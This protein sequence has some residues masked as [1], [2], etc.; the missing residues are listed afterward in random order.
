MKL[1]LQRKVNARTIYRIRE[2]MIFREKLHI[3]DRISYEEFKILYQRYADGMNEKDFARYFFDVDYIEYYNCQAGKTKQM[4]IL[5]R[6]LVLVQEILA[7]KNK[8]IEH[9][10]LKKNDELSYE[11][12]IEIYTQWGN[13]LSLYRFAD[14]VLNVTQKSIQTARMYYNKEEKKDYRMRVLK[15]EN[16]NRH[17]LR[18]IQEKVAKESGK[19]IKDHITLEEFKEL[20]EKFGEGIEEKLFATR[21]LQ[22]DEDRIFRFLKGKVKKVTI[23]NQYALDYEEILA[24]RERVIL[25]EKLHIGDSISKE[26]FER[27]YQKYGGVLSEE[28][29]AE[30]VLDVTAV[31][32]TNMKKGSNS[33]ILTNIE[34]P[35]DYI[36]EVRQ[37]I[38]DENNFEQKQLQ[39]RDKIDSLYEQYGYVLSRK[40]FVEL[41]LDT[42]DNG[43]KRI[44]I[45][46]NQ[47][48]TDFKELRKRVIQEN[49]LHYGDKMRY[50]VFQKLHKKYA[51]NVMEYVFAEKVFD[52]SHACYDKMKAGGSTHILLEEKLPSDAEL[53]QVKETVIR[54]NR[55]HRKDW[56]N[57]QKF[58]EY[59]LK[60]GGILPEDMFAERILDIGINGLKKIRP[61]KDKNNE[62]SEDEEE[63]Q[64]L[65]RTQMEQE[66]IEKLKKKII[67][68]NI[69]Y[70]EKEVSLNDFEEMYRQDEHILSRAE[71]A[72]GVLE[73]GRSSFFRL[74]KGSKVKAFPERKKRSAC[75]SEQEIKLLQE[76]LIQDLS[77]EEI[78]SQMF[79]SLSF[80]EQ[81]REQILNAKKLLLEKKGEKREKEQ[82][83]LSKQQKRQ[84][85]LRQ[86]QRHKE[87]KKIARNVLA[88]F[89]YNEENVSKMKE[90]LDSCKILFETGKLKKEELD[91]LGRCIEFAQAGMEYIEFFLKVCVNFQ[92]YQKA[93][94]FLGENIHNEE[95]KEKEKE[96]LR[97]LRANI[98]HAMK[99]ERAIVMICDQGVRDITYIAQKTGLSRAEIINLKSFEAAPKKVGQFK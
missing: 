81:N 96:K 24:L 57:Y 18:K 25:E 19:H 63:T 90:Y 82:E 69:L 3:G 68:E 31:G 67:N 92:E 29:F 84:A 16:F 38:I 62:K 97:Q 40:Q 72:K 65:L 50:L 2:Q 48:T 30:E 8:V 59:Y 56:I 61:K 76:Y 45:L 78:A 34:I 13:K 93:Y 27:L 60:Y 77:D 32:V 49:A 37:K 36:K 41:I 11:K 4:R 94:V 17:Q 55:L 9:Y 23:L 7:I 33:V 80:L 46:R 71:F 85:V 15:D 91:F 35:E 98:E 44:S 95:V 53:K 99:K 75:F 1:S 83:G 58:R 88:D 86:V 20:Y 74:T 6:E 28:L 39:E 14:E 21:I 5:T 66:E 22:V 52:I 43:N 26:D 10:G 89:D 87:L 12:L 79:V 73:I 70:V 47:E 54:E 42:M 51:P 64:I